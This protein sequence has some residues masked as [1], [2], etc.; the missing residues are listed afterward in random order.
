MRSLFHFLKQKSESEIF[1][2]NSEWIEN[3]KY[4]L[5]NIW[6]DNRQLIIVITFGL[7]VLP[8]AVIVSGHRI[9]TVTD[10][11]STQNKQAEITLHKLNDISSTLHDI[12][13]NPNNSK[14]QQVTFQSLGQN[15]ASVQKSMT[16]VAKSAEVQKVLNQLFST[17]EDMDSQISDLKKSV[18]DGGSN[19]QYLDA[20]A[21][22][23]HVI[24]VDVI[25]GQTYV[26]ID[27]VSHISPLAIS[28]LLAGWRVISADYDS[29]MAEFV[30]EKN[31]YVKVSIQGA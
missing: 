1:I 26:S 17:K 6:D 12:E 16:D 22:P 30:N 13:S 10:L 11:L 3:I 8:I 27:Y 2:K 25:A 15:M 29:G 28:D 31:Q 18:A 24:S 7:I 20:S 19:K 4:K 21:L 14:Q 5:K 23:F 9:K